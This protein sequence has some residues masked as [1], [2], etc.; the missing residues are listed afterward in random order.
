MMSAP[1]ARTSSG[2]IAFTLAAV[3]TGMNAGVRISPRCIEIVPVRALPS[4]AWMVKAKRVITPPASRLAAQAPPGAED[5]RD[6]RDAQRHEGERA[7][8]RQHKR[9]DGMAGKSPPQP[10]DQVEDR[11]ELR[12]RAPRLALF[13]FRFL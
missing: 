7:G 1:V 11:I 4:A 13:L 5:H 6:H 10:V 8:Q 2:R 12:D 3:P 9:H